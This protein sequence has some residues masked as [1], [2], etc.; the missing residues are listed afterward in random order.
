MDKAL[1]ILRKTAYCLN[2]WDDQNLKY[3]VDFN[4]ISETVIQF[5]KF[6]SQLI[7]PAKSY[8]VAIVYAKCMQVFFK[9]EFYQMLN[10]EELLPDDKYFQPYLKS[11]SIYDAVLNEID[12]DSIL[13]SKHTEKTVKYFKREFMI[14]N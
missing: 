10:D 1:Q 13:N 7:Y 11:K 9:K 6:G 5:F 2:E 3:E 4:N 12:I 14:C 8:F